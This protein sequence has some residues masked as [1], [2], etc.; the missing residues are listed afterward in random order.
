[1]TLRTRRRIAAQILK[2]GQNKII[3]IKDRLADIKEAIT[4]EDMRG[5]IKEGAI[6]AKKSKGISKGRFRKKLSQ[7]KKGL[8]KGTGKRK[9]KRVALKFGKKVWMKKIRVL[10]RVLAEHKDKLDNKLY[11]RLRREIKAG[12]VKTKRHLA[13][14]I[15]ERKE[16]WEEEKERLK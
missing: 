13:E 2:V 11:W 1:M 6:K 8:R 3:F 5:L 16:E 4:K 10:R 7:K 12:S 9:G 15:K 14:V